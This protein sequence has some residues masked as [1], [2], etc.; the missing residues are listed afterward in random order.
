MKR[1]SC[2]NEVDFAEYILEEVG[3]A[4]VP[5]PAFGA[6]AFVKKLS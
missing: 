1:V 3:L 6:P 2:D 5:G 4:T